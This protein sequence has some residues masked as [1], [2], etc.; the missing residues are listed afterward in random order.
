[1]RFVKLGVIS[2]I[3]LFAVITVIGLL[4]PRNVTTTRTINIHVPADTLYRYLVDVKYW[5]LWMQGAKDTTIQF[6]SMKTAG[7][8]TV[9]RIGANEVS[10][11]KANPSSVSMV[12]QGK[13]G[14]IMQSGFEIMSDPS[15]KIT[16]VE[17]YFQ[18]HL[19]WYPWKRFASMMNDKV[20]GPG[21]E[22]SLDSLK[23][24]VEGKQ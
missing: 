20:L 21:M 17:W 9:A 18:Q 24:F 19:Q 3:V 13:R 1:M 23:A 5:K 14:N 12:W 6:L 22:T 8:G 11:L 15:N 10:I 2:I 4:F 16:T 7:E